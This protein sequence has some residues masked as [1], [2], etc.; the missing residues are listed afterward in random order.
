MGMSSVSFT[1]RYGN[2]KELFPPPPPHQFT[3]CI[4]VEKGLRFSKETGKS[5]SVYAR[6]L[7]RLVNKMLN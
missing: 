6:S 5:A 3:I 7:R 2:E 1:S 4:T